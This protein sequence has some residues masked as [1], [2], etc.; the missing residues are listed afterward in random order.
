[1]LQVEGG[2]SQSANG[3]TTR[4]SRISPPFAHVSVD[5]GC[6]LMVKGDNRRSKVN[7]KGYIALFVCMITMAI[8]FEL[9]KDLRSEPFLSAVKR[10]VARRERPV[11]IYSDNDTNFLGASAELKRFFNE[12]QNLDDTHNLHTGMGID[13]KFIPRGIK[14]TK[15]LIKK[16]LGNTVLNL[17]EMSTLLCQ[18]EACLNSRPLC[19]MSNDPDS[20][21]YPTPGHFLIHRS[22]TATPESDLSDLPAN[23]LSRWQLQHIFQS[24]WRHWRADYLNQLQR[25]KWKKESP[26]APAEGDIILREDRVSLLSWRMVVIED[27]HPGPEG[28][29]RVVTLRT[30]QG[31]FRRPISK[32]CPLPSS[33]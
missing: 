11:C 1:M 22:P 8:H 23:H 6:P 4:L 16:V 20:L 3:T 10:F 24:F 14:S 28:L 12:K 13:W 15:T 9:V 33:D 27:L 19:S 31:T 17:E 30:A 5:Y 29:L 18:I 7:F 21:C 2:R 32:L 25:R 26:W